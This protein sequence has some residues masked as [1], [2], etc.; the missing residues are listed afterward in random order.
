VRTLS[1]IHRWAGGF[2][3]LLLA[4]LGLTGSILLWEGAWLTLPG[5]SDPVAENVSTI[6]RISE[7]AAAAGDLSRI[8]FAGEETALHLLTY[9]DGS[10][11]Y[12]RQ[13]GAI[14]DRWSSQWE[15]P[16][17][18]LFDLHHHLFAGEAGETV[19]GIAGVAGLLFVITG[20]LL[21]LRSRGRFN[22]R[23]L[24]KRFTPGAIV[25]HHRDLGMLVAPLL[26]LSLTTGVLMVFPKAANAVFSPFA[27]GQAGQGHRSNVQS[28][29]GQ[30]IALA[31]RQS[32]QLFPDAA[33]RRITM[34][35]SRIGVRMKQPFEWTPNGRTQLTFGAT[36]RLLKIDDPASGPL[37]GA[38][39]EKLYPIHSAKVGS[40]G[41]KLLM[42]VSGL[43]LAV[44]GLLATWSFWIRRLNHSSL[45][46]RTV[47]P[48]SRKR[49]K[50]AQ[51]ASSGG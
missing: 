48:T 9:A 33:L 2:L 51:A 35:G 17:L 14:V 18:W 49:R 40:T 16:E 29:G 28:Q 25:K 41:M 20:T 12:V 34:S 37:S 1:A 36:G 4:L 8:T 21:W 46:M 30:P 39:E 38:I 31:L 22:P 11:A 15:R 26:F 32:K 44:L 43:S 47:S 5:A 7:R 3:G 19:T 27:V 10:G 42:T 45:R 24:P 13:D 6:A 50:G 23:L